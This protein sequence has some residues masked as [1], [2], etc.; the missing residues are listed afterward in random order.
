MLKGKL[1]AATV[2]QCDVYYEGS[3]SI[4]QD[5]LDAAGILP[6]ERVDIW[7]ITNGERISTYAIEAPRGSRTIG[8]NG[9]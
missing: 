1:H 3:V 4:D 8:I 7:N 5:L 2:T 9:G 6:H